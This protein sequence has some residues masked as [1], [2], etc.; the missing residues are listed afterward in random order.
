ML[1]MPLNEGGLI[2]ESGRGFSYRECLVSIWILDYNVHS[3]DLLCKLLY[4]GI[5]L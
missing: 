1:S 4:H 5:A 2:H 3:S